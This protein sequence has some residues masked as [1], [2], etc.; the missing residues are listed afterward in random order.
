MVDRAV[1]RV[2]QKI[3]DLQM[4]DNSVVVFT[5]DHG[6][7]LGEHDRV[8]KSNCSDG[9]DPRA[10]PLYP[11]IAH[12]PCL[13]AAPGLA[14][15]RRMEKIV[16]T[17]DILPT[18]ADLAGVSADPPTPFHGRSFAPWLRD[19]RGDA[20]RDF[21]IAGAPFDPDKHDK[22]QLK[23]PVFYTEKWGVAP[24][25]HDGRGQVFDIEADPLAENDRA[26][27]HEDLLVDVRREIAEWLKAQDAPQTSIEPFL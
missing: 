19:E 5:S 12:V 27:D 21:A 6:V 3:D 2:L 14:G 7:S 1:G 11:E 22:R 23:P 15:G 18:C 4:W 20:F 25:G 8:G 24:Y 10:W 13:I 17:P 9:A 26:A 16:Q